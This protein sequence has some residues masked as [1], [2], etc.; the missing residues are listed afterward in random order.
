[1]RQKLTAG[2]L[3]P[4]ATRPASLAPRRNSAATAQTLPAPLALRSAAALTPPSTHTTPRAGAQLPI[5]HEGRAAFIVKAYGSKAPAP[6]EQRFP[7][8][9]LPAVTVTIRGPTGRTLFDKIVGAW[10]SAQREDEPLR[11]LRIFA[12]ARARFRRCHAAHGRGIPGRGVGRVLAL[13]YQP[14]DMGCGPLR[15]HQSAVLALG[16]AD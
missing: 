1:M 3:K 11:I 16:F 14:P 15:F 13:L 6:K 7:G 2:H 12:R 8:G 9:D 5:P 10:R 4:G